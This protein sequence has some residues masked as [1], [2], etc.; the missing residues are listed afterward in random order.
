M[1][2]KVSDAMDERVRF[3]V[4]VEG[5]T[6][7]MVAVCARFGIS[8]ETGY[9]WLARY[10][11][12][13]FA[14]LSDGSRARHHQVCATSAEI[15]AALL[16]LRAARPRWGPKKLR[17]F[18]ARERPDVAWPA[19]STIG[20]VLKRGGL[21]GAR[22]IGGRGVEQYQ[23]HSMAIEPNDLW[24][25]DFKGWFRTKDGRRCDPL[26]VSDTMS[27]ML[28]LCEIVEPSLQ[29]VWPACERLFGAW[30]QPRAFRM[31]NGSPFGSKGA[32]GLTKLSV[33]FVKLGIALEPITP[34]CPGENGRHE[35]MHRTLGDETSSP[36]AGSRSEL[37]ARFD[38][39]RVDFN[40][41]RPH[42]ALEQRTPASMHRPNARLYTGR[43]DD[44]WYDW[45]HLEHRVTKQGY[46]R[47]HDQP[48]YI[49]EALGGELVG[50][51]ELASGDHVVRFAAIDVGVIGREAKNFIRLSAPRPGRAETEHIMNTVSHVPGPKC[52]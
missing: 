43:L 23:A 25:I 21:V 26:T 45:T 20:D 12:N 27:R 35:R 50:V 11:A 2:W 37:Q 34:G 10:R 13:G 51:A 42:E 39:F 38:R 18:L 49:S 32:G 33:R 17:A 40:E 9:K 22:R 8:R 16:A 1:P 31:D 47:W 19:A 48:L 7:P 29:G 52:Q 3:V 4:A 28:L 5:A 30:G 44:P 15:C 24:G 14:G 46:I 36:A 41:V 6:E